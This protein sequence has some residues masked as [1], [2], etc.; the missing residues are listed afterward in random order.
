MIARTARPARP[1]RGLESST[2]TTSGH[3][4]DV[5]WRALLRDA[6]R[7]VGELLELLDLTTEDVPPWAEAEASFPLLVPRAFVARMRRGDPRDPLLLQVLPTAQEQVVSPGF[8]ED[9]IGE[10]LATAVPGV[11]HKYRGRAL[12][13]ATGACAIHCRYCFR[14]HF[15]YEE[16]SAGALREALSYLERET[17]LEE[18]ILSGG[19]PLSLSDCRLDELLAALEAN[20]HLRR[21]RFHTRWPVLIPERITDPLLDRISSS[22]LRPV[23]V[24]HANHPRELDDAVGEGLCRLAARMTVLNQSVLLAGVNDS[25]AA[26]RGLAERLF[27]LGVL[28]YYLHA[29]DPVAGAGHFAV[30]DAEAERL[31]WRLAAELPGYLVPRL[32]REIPGAPS[33]VPLHPG[34][35]ASS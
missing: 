5:D 18:V 14:R 12:V 25:V 23:V 30:A 7:S 15:P 21:V 34:R 1:G 33:K 19:D 17:T 27:E 20:P 26:L 13:I 2:A 11:L 8:G 16:H 3:G 28:P 32:V 24:I 10:G 35:F 9:P 22:R 29:L 6:V 4:L 31:V